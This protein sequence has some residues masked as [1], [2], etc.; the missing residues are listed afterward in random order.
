LKQSSIKDVW[1]VSVVFVSNEAKAVCVPVAID[2]TSLV[3]TNA[4]S[5]QVA[6]WHQKLAAST[7]FP[8]VWDYHVVLI[9]RLRSEHMAGSQI[10]DAADAPE[11]EIEAWVYD[12]DSLLPKPCNWKEYIPM[13]FRRTDE[14]P[15]EF[16]SLFRVISADIYLDYFASDRSHMLMPSLLNLDSPGYKPD[17]TYFSPVP[18]WPAIRGAKADQP[19]TLMSDF[20]FMRSPSGTSG[21]IG[22]VKDRTTLEKWC[23]RQE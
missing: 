9:L 5:V 21:G 15:L 2:S 22:V 23:C 11:C 8:V 3:W 20:V 17:P 10:S 4:L 19:D 14:V 16:R 1:D 18:P 13:T 7:D 6:L 12:F